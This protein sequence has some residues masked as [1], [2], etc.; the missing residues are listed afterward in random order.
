MGLEP[1]RHILGWFTAW[2]AAGLPTELGDNSTGRHG[3]SFSESLTSPQGLT[4]DIRS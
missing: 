2:R 4:L 1:I 3:E